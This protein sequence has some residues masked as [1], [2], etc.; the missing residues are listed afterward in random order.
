MELAMHWHR[1]SNLSEKCMSTSRVYRERDH[2]VK[3]GVANEPG[4]REMLY[5]TAATKQSYPYCVL[6]VLMFC[7][8]RSRS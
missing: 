5:L 4:L 7:N 6:A 3:D 8:V 2:P 1:W